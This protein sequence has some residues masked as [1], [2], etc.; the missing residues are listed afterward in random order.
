[1]MQFAVYDPLIACLHWIVNKRHKKL[2]RMCQKCRGIGQGFNETYDLSDAEEEA[3]RRKEKDEK[4]RKKS[5]KKAQRKAK[6]SAAGNKVSLF[7]EDGG[8][9]TQG[10]AGAE[11]D[12]VNN[13]GGDLF[14]EDQSACNGHR[15]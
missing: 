4:E 15:G 3:K 8:G 12:T 14:G 11:E 7:G 9:G 2:G 5:E 10:N 13:R 1:M 6:K